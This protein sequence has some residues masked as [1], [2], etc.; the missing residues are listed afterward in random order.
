M[1]PTNPLYPITRLAPMLFITVIAI[2]LITLLSSCSVSNLPEDQQMREDLHQT[3]KIHRNIVG[4][5]NG[6]VFKKLK[7]YTVTDSEGKPAMKMRIHKGDTVRPIGGVF[8]L[9][10]EFNLQH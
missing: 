4:Y 7:Y 3:T 9:I 2:F 5:E 1:K 8:L 10:D 6:K